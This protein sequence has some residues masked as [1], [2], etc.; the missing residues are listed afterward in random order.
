MAIDWGRTGEVLGGVLGGGM[1]VVALA[2]VRRWLGYRI[3]REESV[4]ARYERLID[5]LQSQLRTEATARERE[6]QEHRDQLGL[7]QRQMA[8][9]MESNSALQTHIAALSSAAQQERDARA[10]MH[11]LYEALST[12]HQ[13]L[14]IELQE[15]KQRLSESEAREAA[16]RAEVA[17][18]R[19]QVQAYESGAHGGMSSSGP[20]AIGR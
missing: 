14:K 12:E 2:V 13:A 8:S 1:G 19:A 10:R 15:T 6:R 5:E 17:G 18:L 4:D 20:D 3:R 7:V 9:V 11:L 16:L